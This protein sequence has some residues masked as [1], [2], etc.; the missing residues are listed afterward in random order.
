MVG[1]VASFGVRR[2]RLVSLLHRLLIALLSSTSQFKDASHVDEFSDERVLV[3]EVV[4]VVVLELE[5]RGSL[6]SLIDDYRQD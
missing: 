3:S 1:G 4:D 5:E 2:I 6:A